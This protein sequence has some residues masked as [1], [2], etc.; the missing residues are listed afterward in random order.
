[1]P[2]WLGIPIGPTSANRLRADAAGLLHFP[3]GLA[4]GLDDQGDGALAG[5]VVGDGERDPL[6]FGVGHDDDELPGP[7]RAG[8]PRVTDL[9]QVGHVGEIFASDDLVAGGYWFPGHG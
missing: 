9:E 8:H 6:A 7:R 3:R 4:D 5:I 2:T 1:L